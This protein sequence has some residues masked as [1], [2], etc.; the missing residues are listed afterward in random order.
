MERSNN[1]I[2]QMRSVRGD[3]MELVCSNYD[4]LEETIGV[5]GHALHELAIDPEQFHPYLY[6]LC[7]DEKRTRQST[8]DLLQ[9]ARQILR[10]A[11]KASEAD[12][13]EESL[14]EVEL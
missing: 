1:V 7:D 2:E 4:L 12:E 10:A 9:N 5:L 11:L 14:V 6:T 3:P 13:D 8:N